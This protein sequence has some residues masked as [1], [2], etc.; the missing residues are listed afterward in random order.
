MKFDTSSPPRDEVEF[1]IDAAALAKANNPPI[2]LVGDPQYKGKKWEIGETKEGDVSNPSALRLQLTVPKNNLEL[3]ADKLHKS[4][5]L[6]LRVMKRPLRVLLFASAATH[7]FQ[8][9]NNMML[10]EVEQQRADLAVY[11]QPPPGKQPEEWFK[12]VVLGVKP[13]RL[14]LHFP[15]RYDQPSDD[16]KEQIY[17]LNEYDVIVAFDPDWSKLSDDQ[18]KLVNT[19]CSKGGGLVMVGGPINTLQLA[20]PGPNKVKLQ[21]VLDLLPV[22]LADVRINALER[23]P[24]DPWPLTWG[25][26]ANNELEFLRLTEEGDQENVSFKEGWNQFFHGNKEGTG[27]VKRGFFNYYPTELVK[28]GSLVVARF[29]DPKAKMKDGSQM[30]FLVLNAAGSQHRVVWI[31]WGETRRLRQNSEAF[32]ERFWIKML[33][34]AGAHNQTDLVRRVRLDMS[35]TYTAGHTCRSK[36]RSTTAAVNR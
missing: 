23:I 29:G 36:P 27:P 25:D 14:L 21:P 17:D 24:V 16:P 3:F 8:F 28:S 1:V 9:L 35:R 6:D 19:W 5:I 15:T 30:P 12:T 33:R 13:D 31:A 22:V 26:A 18:L 32:Y 7:D 11:V 10:R 4:D 2:D 20:R 34:Y